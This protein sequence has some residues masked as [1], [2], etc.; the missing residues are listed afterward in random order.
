MIHLKREI[1][2]TSTLMVINLLPSPHMNE[3]CLILERQQRGLDHGW[4]RDLGWSV[5]FV[6]LMPFSGP[7]A[8]EGYQ[9]RLNSV[10]KKQFN[11]SLGAPGIT[12][13]STLVTGEEPMVQLANLL[14]EEE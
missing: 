9:T 13:K 2:I 8:V 14:S 5:Q 1:D 4:R 10:L 7:T 12:F 3:L 6:T 11:L